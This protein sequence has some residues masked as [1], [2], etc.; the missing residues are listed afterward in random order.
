M[1]E[2]IK[3]PLREPQIGIHSASIEKSKR[4]G[5]V[6]LSQGK[7]SSH[8]VGANGGGVNVAHQRQHPGQASGVLG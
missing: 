8:F 5:G 1:Q 4:L 2:P 7:P 3:K 6:V